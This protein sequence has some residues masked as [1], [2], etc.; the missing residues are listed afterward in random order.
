MHKLTTLT[1]MPWQFSL[2][3]SGFFLGVPVTAEEKRFTDMF[4]KLKARILEIYL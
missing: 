1:I 4:H 2:R 3:L